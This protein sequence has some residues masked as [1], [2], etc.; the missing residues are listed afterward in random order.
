MVKNATVDVNCGSVYQASL[1]QA[2]HEGQVEEVTI[3]ESFQ[4]MARIQFRLGLFDSGKKEKGNPQADIASIDS[5]E[6]Q[7]LALEAALQSIVLLQNKDS[8]LPLNKESSLA[9]IGPHIDGREVFMANYHG[10]RCECSA[11]KGVHN[12]VTAQ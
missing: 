4:R 10:D 9:I 8:L 7:Q 5:P 6:H 1:S 11:D 3:N 2:F 12:P